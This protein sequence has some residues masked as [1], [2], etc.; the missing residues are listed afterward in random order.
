[1]GSQAK[2]VLGTCRERGRLTVSP[3][4]GHPEPGAGLASNGFLCIHS[5]V[6]DTQGRGVCT[7]WA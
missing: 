7:L 6:E 5:S 3:W 1:M 4:L 2:A